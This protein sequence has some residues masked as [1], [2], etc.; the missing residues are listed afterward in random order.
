MLKLTIPRLWSE[1][2]DVIDAVC[3]NDS[4]LHLPMKTTGPAQPTAFSQVEYCFSM[5]DSTPRREEKDHP[6]AF[7]AIT[8]LGFYHVKEG[9]LILWTE[10]KV[11][12]FPPGSTF[13]FPAN[14]VRYSFC[15][16]EEPGHQ[17]LVSQ[18][19][20]AGL[21][22]FVAHG[23]DDRF[24]PQPR[25][26]SKAAERLDREERAQ[27]AVALYSTVEEFDVAQADASFNMDPSRGE[28]RVV[29]GEAQNS[30][31]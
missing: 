5:P 2:R 21:H 11:V 28:Y 1:T 12:N 26:E 27:A 22:G 23:F 16:V 6:P 8:S 17:M 15:G 29:L 10:R 14:L 31:Q 4:S 30:N 20:G 3:E 25:F 9:E 24:T 18:S 13:L 7:R 19:C